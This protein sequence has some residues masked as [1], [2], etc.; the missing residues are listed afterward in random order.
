MKRNHRR[1]LALGVLLCLLLGCCGCTG[2]DA[3]DDAGQDAVATLAAVGDIYLTTPMLVDAR[4][5]DG[6]Y[7]FGALF[8]CVVPA[9][10]AADVTI[11]NFE[12]CFAGAPYG[13]TEGSYPDDLAAAL[14]SAGFDLLQT[15]NSFSIHNGISGLE[16]TRSILLGQQL[17]PLG[18]YTSQDERK[19]EKAILLEINGIRFVFIAF[20]KGLNGMSIPSGSEYCV[21]L[22]YRD[23]DS[24]YSKIDYDA[25]DEILDAARK[26]EPDVIVAALHWG[27]EN[28][29]EVSESQETIADYLF[30]NDV[31]VI[32]GSHSHIAGEIEERTVT[33]S[34]GEEKTVVAAY[35]LGDFCSAEVGEVNASLILQLE[36][37]RSAESGRTV[38][39]DVSYTPIA[40][41]DLGEGNT[42]RF[43]VLNIDDAISLYEN[44]YYARVSEDVYEALL[45]QR[46]ALAAR[47]EP[48][49]AE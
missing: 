8:S 2:S 7:D 38:I 15:A 5:A 44:N 25:I 18:T 3:S 30:R 20:T 40:T 43:A 36:F 32:L 29:S 22:L 33:T 47:V 16:R 28:I 4:A 48:T 1:W 31:D 46:E 17:I 23:Y 49:E 24:T 39:S 21:N 19:E 26:L 11:G 9:L 34:S 27:S 10:C 41:A 42:E 6:S 12:G 37:T 14:C 13:Q 45:A 35:S